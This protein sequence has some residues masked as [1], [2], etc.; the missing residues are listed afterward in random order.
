[1]STTITTA[2]EL[3]PEPE[4][5]I[6]QLFILLHGVGGTPASLE[7]LAQAL[8]QAFPAS[9]VLI[10]AGAQPFDGGG[11]GRQWF[12]IRGVTETN[13][14]ER[15]AAAL[16]SLVSYIQAQQQRLGLLQ[17][18]TALAGFS[19]GAIMA[20]EAVQA[21]DGLAGR[22]MAFSGRYASLPKAPPQYTTIHI[23]HGA[24]DPVIEAVHAQ[25][26]QARLAELHG[27]ATI[28]IAS[29]VGHELHP[30]LIERAIVR[31]KTC[32]PLRSWEA[33]LGLNQTPPEGSSVH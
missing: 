10:P 14:P 5:E 15:V 28:D 32:V 2:I 29:S 21:H 27:D 7:N 26:A 23:L 25:A 1:M 17:S 20:L 3:L 16:P 24:A 6:K 19:Q 30:A 9:A 33:A 31:L 8:R 11:E 22:V 13:R 18:D 4:I 12:S